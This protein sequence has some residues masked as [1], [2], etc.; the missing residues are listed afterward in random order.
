MSFYD[1]IMK[2][3]PGLSDAICVECSESKSTL[4]VAYSGVTG[5]RL[6]FVC[7]TTSPPAHLPRGQGHHM[8][9][10]ESEGV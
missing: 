3:T 10:K 2:I 7:L 4:V 5:V 9:K 1:V 8:E 6:G